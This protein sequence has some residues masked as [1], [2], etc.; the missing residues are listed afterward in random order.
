MSLPKIISREDAAKILSVPNTST[1]MGL[2]NRSILQVLY[3]CGLR[4]Q[5]LCNLTTDDVDL[6]KGFIYVQRGKG[7]KDRYVPMDWETL[8]WCKQWADARADWLTKKG[9]QSDYFFCT[10]K[11]TQLKTR[12]LRSYFADLSEKTGVYIRDGKERKAIHPHIFRHTCF[13]ECLED[14]LSVREVQELAGHASLNTTMVYLAVRPEMLAAKMRNRGS[15][16]GED[17]N[18]AP[19]D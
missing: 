3:R 6:E 4:S 10:M 17:E 14:G 12:W 7:G 11:G 8:E 13:T 5:E 15:V 2:R 9:V 18:R 1:T 16:G 19:V